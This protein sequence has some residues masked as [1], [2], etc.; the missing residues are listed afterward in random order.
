M[1]L[2]ETAAEVADLIP[3]FSWTIMDDDQRDDLMVNVVLPRYMAETA[4]G[5]KLGPVW[6][7]NVLGASSGTIQK[8]VERLKRKAFA[9]SD[10]TTTSPTASH[11]GNVRGAKSAIRKHPELAAKLLDDPEVV[12]AIRQASSE[13]FHEKHPTKRTKRDPEMKK[14]SDRLGS[15]I[16]WTELKKFKSWAL[17][18]AEEWRGRD[19]TD[20]QRE[21]VLDGIEQA[22]GALAGL[23][24]AMDFDAELDNL[25]SEMEGTA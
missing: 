12:E 9:G 21:M 17:R 1:P 7:A 18:M 6:W 22:E 24:A 23:R 3:R 19:W 25:I 14:L 11:T 20:K 13:A 16:D 2:T 10:A 15:I 5:V 4:D 8:R